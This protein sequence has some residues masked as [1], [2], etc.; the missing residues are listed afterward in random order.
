MWNDNT[1]RCLL[2][3]KNEVDIKRC[4]KHQ[5]LEKRPPPAFPPTTDGQHLP[6]CDAV[7]KHL[8]AL[9]T[10]EVAASRAIPAAAKGM[11]MGKVARL[12]G[13]LVPMCMR[14]WPGTL[15]TCVLAAKTVS[16]LQPCRKYMPASLKELEEKMTP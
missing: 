9:A 8:L 6:T 14:G 10:R 5:V 1:R 3:A 7:I 15:K 13:L 12:G 16:E 11:A 4:K 2:E